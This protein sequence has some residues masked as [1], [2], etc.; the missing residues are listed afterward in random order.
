MTEFE[1]RVA[2]V[3]GSA[4]GIGKEIA[5]VLLDDG[6]IELGVVALDEDGKALQIMR[7]WLTAMPGETATRAFSSVSLA[8]SS[9]PAQA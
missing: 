4:R 7:S 1:D 6:A 2:V 3:T 8:N 5:R 9:E